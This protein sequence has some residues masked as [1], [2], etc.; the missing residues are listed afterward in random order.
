MFRSKGLKQGPEV[1]QIISI[2]PLMCGSWT[3]HY[4]KVSGLTS[5]AISGTNQTKKGEEDG[6]SPEKSSVCMCISI[7]LGC[8]SRGQCSRATN[9]GGS[10]GGGWENQECMSQKVNKCPEMKDFVW[11]MKKC[12]YTALHVYLLPEP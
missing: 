5:A 2:W 4:F 11:W 3:F 12:K 10:T 6:S 8:T 1:A 9:S 7:I